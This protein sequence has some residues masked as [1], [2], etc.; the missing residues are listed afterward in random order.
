MYVFLIHKIVWHCRTHLARVTFSPFQALRRHTAIF[1]T[2]MARRWLRQWRLCL[3]CRISGFSPWVGKIPWRRVWHPTPVFLTRE[4]HGQGSLVGHSPSGRQESNT[5]EVT[6]PAC[7]Y[8]W[9]W[10]AFG[11]SHPQDIKPLASFL[12]FLYSS[13]T[14]LIVLDCVQCAADHN[15]STPE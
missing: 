15:I 10:H 7:T 1:G 5:V 6:E 11:D 4:S 9:N 12:L 13:H 3:K 8:C 2:N 14:L